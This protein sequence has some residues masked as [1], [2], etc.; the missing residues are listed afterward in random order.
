[1]AEHSDSFTELV[2]ELVKAYPNVSRVE[3]TVRIGTNGEQVVI[4]AVEF[5]TMPPLQ[6]C[7][8]DIHQSPEFTEKLKKELAKGPV[9]QFREFT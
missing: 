7:T 9:V 3:Q 8:F 6:P 2:S 5:H 4:C 1:M